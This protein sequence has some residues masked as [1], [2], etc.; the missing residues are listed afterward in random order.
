MHHPNISPNGEIS[1]EVIIER[2]VNKFY[3]FTATIQGNI[4][5]LNNNIII[6]LTNPLPIEVLDENINLYTVFP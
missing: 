4:Q 6:V 5:L 1:P 2:Y 3:S